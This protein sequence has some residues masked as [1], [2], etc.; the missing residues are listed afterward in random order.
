MNE[1]QNS[2]M[3]ARMILIYLQY[4]DEGYTENLRLISI[5]IKEFSIEVKK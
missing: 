3:I 2:D 5:L 4:S 1:Q